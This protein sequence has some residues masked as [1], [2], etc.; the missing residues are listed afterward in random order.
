MA[1]TQISQIRHRRGLQ[2]DLPQLA[3]AELGWSVDTQKLYIG[4]GTIE[5]G[6]PEIGNT[7]LLTEADLPFA[8]GAVTGQT[9]TN[10]TTANIIM[11]NNLLLDSTYPGVKMNYV[12]TRGGN[13]RVGTFNIAQLGNVVAYDD[14]YSESANIGISFL[15]TQVANTYA[16]ISANTSNQGTDANLQFSITTIPF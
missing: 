9:L 14:E 13:V 6:A 3:S 16:Q 5:E 1:I 11:P 2:S 8:N 12:I 7:R 10:N 4:N 15:V